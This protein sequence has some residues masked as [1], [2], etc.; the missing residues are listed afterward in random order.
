M[1][2]IFAKTPKG[3]SEMETRSGGLTPRVRR[4]LIMVDGKRTV[5]DL[6]AMALADDLTHTLGLL[7]E[8]GYIQVHQA[9]DVAADDNGAL[10][11]ITAFRELPESP[12]GRE[13]DMARHFIVNTLKTFCGQMTHLTI[14]EA[15]FTAKTH[16]ELREV[17][18]PWYHAMV[19]T[20][21]GR[22]RAEELREDLLKVI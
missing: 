10:P 2:V 4:L 17:F 8:E 6:R 21:E 3:V 15:A 7:E 18:G 9:L 16:A 11:S 19:E 14:V 1:S 5:E 20:R 12:D 13:L 22:R